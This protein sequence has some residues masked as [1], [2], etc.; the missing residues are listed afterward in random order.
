MTDALLDRPE[1]ILDVLSQDLEEPIR[2]NAE[3][4][5]ISPTSLD[6]DLQRLQHLSLEA[7]QDRWR[8]NY[9][10]RAPGRLGAEFLRR[11]LAYRLQE[12]ALGGLS[13]QAQLRLKAWS[14]RPRED[15][16][17]A[18]SMPMPVMIKSGTR[19]VREWQGETHEVLAIESGTYIYKSKI[20][21]SL[22]VIAREITGTHQSGPRF[23]GLRRQDIKSQGLERSH[24]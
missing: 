23:F 20:F 6:S 22:T 18:R 14:Q 16:G 4:Q 15:D 10:Q 2:T 1:Q 21:R 17:R 7:L 24:V 9:G 3:T 5:T 19:F 11:A 8:T 12:T 13:R